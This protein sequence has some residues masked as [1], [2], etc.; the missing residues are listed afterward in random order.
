MDLVVR[1]LREGYVH[2]LGMEGVTSVNE[3]F[4][5]LHPVAYYTLIKAAQ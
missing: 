5:L 1:G 2:E 4:K 3:G